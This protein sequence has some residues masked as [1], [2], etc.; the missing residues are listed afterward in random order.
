[1]RISAYCTRDEG[2]R[3][4]TLMVINKRPDSPAE[5][6]VVLEGFA[7]RATA[8]VATLGGPHYLS[9]NDDGATFR[10]VTPAPPVTVVIAESALKAAGLSF[11][12]KFPEHSITV[13]ELQAR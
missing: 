3:R 8:K 7:P 9:H 4:L 5:T 10:S 11:R 2:R 12:Y 13:I 1:M 6:T